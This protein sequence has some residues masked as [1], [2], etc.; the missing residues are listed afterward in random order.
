M[1][2]SSKTNQTAKQRVLKRYPAAYSIPV[3][4]NS[5]WAW[6]IKNG[7]N[8]TELSEECDSARQA[9]ADAAR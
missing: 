9:W 5:W 7:A 3:F 6:V 2:I 1:N 8:G 4:R